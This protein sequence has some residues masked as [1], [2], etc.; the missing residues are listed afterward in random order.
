IAFENNIVLNQIVIFDV[1]G[2]SYNAK[3]VA[4]NNL[5]TVDISN[6]P[7]G[8]YFLQLNNGKQFLSSKFL[9]VR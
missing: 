4:E 2:N 1:F 9:V 7:S 8:I 6:L 3:F 5:V